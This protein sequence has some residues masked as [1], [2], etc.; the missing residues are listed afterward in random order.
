VV[1]AML[2]NRIDVFDPGP[3]MGTPPEDM[4]RGA[5]YTRT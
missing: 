2:V 5:V 3:A 4:K 1:I